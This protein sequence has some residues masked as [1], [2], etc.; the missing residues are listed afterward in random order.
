MRPPKGYYIDKRTG[1]YKVRLM[2]EG[3]NT[4]IA[5]VDTEKEARKI[6]LETREKYPKQPAGPKPP[7]KF[8]QSTY[9]NKDYDFTGTPWY[10]L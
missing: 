9:R 1:K 10:G 6:Y 5:T 2:I 7:I 3:K 8:I 4:Y